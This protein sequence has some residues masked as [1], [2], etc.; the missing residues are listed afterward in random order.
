M[1]LIPLT[2][3]TYWRLC[4]FARLLVLAAAAVAGLALPV[5]SHAGERFVYDDL[6]RL[7]ESVDEAGNQ[8]TYTYD[9]AGNILSVQT[10]TSSV[11]APAITLLSP[12]A[13]TLGATVTI[14][15]GGTN[16]TGAALTTDNPGIV[17]S[18]V[19]STATTIKLTLP[20]A[21]M[22]AW[23]PPSLRSWHSAEPRPP[24][25]TSWRATRR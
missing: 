23:V 11:Q 8:A 17:I 15:I 19:S 25:S 12:A 6:G 24:A 20:S 14:S 4:R 16:L 2:T 18:G 21:M 1:A 13:G 22:P 10:G 9:V 5:L 7:I 3:A